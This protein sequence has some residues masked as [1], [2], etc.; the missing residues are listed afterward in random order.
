[1]RCWGFFHIIS[2]WLLTRFLRSPANESSNLI[3][4]KKK[5]ENIINFHGLICQYRERK[6]C[7]NKERK[8]RS[9]MFELYNFNL[10]CTNESIAFYIY[11][12]CA[13]HWAPTRYVSYFTS[14]HQSWQTAT[15]SW[16]LIPW[17]T[18]HKK[19]IMVC[20]ESWDFESLI[21]HVCLGG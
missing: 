20:I 9:Q 19:V 13:T 2:L 16:H 17:Q 18:T 7:K 15:P 12:F 10:T 21:F 1:M 11:I 14:M 4:I 3:F 8:E 5:I 6:K